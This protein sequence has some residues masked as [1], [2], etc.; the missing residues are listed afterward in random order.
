MI[1]TI[2]TMEVFVAARP[3]VVP[4]QFKPAQQL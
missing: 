2:G 3:A 4:Y 1:A